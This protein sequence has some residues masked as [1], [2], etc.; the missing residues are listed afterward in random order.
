MRVCDTRELHIIQCTI[1]TYLLDDAAAQ[2]GR[3]DGG[4]CGGCLRCTHGCWAD[5]AVSGL[6]GGESGRFSVCTLWFVY[7]EDTVRSYWGGF[8]VGWSTL[9]VQARLGYKQQT[10][11]HT[12]TYTVGTSVSIGE[13]GSFGARAQLGDWCDV[14]LGR[15]RAHTIKRLR[16]ASSVGRL[17]NGRSVSNGWHRTVRFSSM[18][19]RWRRFLAVLVVS[20]AKTYLEFGWTLHFLEIV[21]IK[22]IDQTFNM[23]KRMMC[24][25]RKEKN[26]KSHYNYE[27][28]NVNHINSVCRYLNC[29]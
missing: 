3:S 15:A 4:R 22:K 10:H 28:K 23:L 21:R 12:H 25:K 11:T 19:R 26:T 16:Y 27:Y 29:F 20:G 18:S 13:G 8:G 14:R 24:W 6:R 9:S 17:R 2:G 7:V 1:S 5:A